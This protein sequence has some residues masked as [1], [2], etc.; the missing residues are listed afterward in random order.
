MRSKESFFYK[1]CISD[2]IIIRSE[3]FGG[4]IFNPKKEITIKVDIPAFNV[5]KSI[6]D[7]NFHKN[8]LNSTNELLDFLYRMIRL[9]IITQRKR[10]FII[11]PKLYEYKS[12]INSDII[13]FPESLHITLTYNCNQ[14]CKGCY[15]GLQKT[16]FDMHYSLYKQILDEAAREGILQLALGGGEPFYHPKIWEFLKYT[17]EKEILMNITTNGTLLNK[18]KILKLEKF[19]N[20]GRIQIS[21]DG[22]NQSINDQSRPN[23][24]KVLDTISNLS[25]SNIRFG[26]N[27]LLRNSNI[28]NL[29]DMFEFCRDHGANSLNLLRIKPP[30]IDRNWFEKEKLNMKSIEKLSDFLESY[31]NRKKPKI[32]F[33]A[34]F[35][36][37]IQKK[38][39]NLLFLN[40]YS[41]CSGGKNFLT[42]LPDGTII[43][44]THLR[45]K[46][47][48]VKAGIKNIWENSLEL[49]FL[50]NKKN[51]IKEPCK[52][53]EILMYCGGCRALALNE[54]G[55]FNGID[56]E[57]LIYKQIN[58]EV[59]YRNKKA[60]ISQ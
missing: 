35:S 40:D 25:S 36:Y 44:C 8:H 50:R 16:R 39:I 10:N 15:F 6:F 43:P 54:S 41:G 57:C 14:E 49:K 31:K 2:G 24:N 27:M 32:Y 42:I 5:L 30:I 1:Y 23:F 9:G 34:S 53:C 11:K 38:Q 21:L 26:I 22:T 47:G 20:L 33:D 46:I 3:F 58:N 28:N 4:L 60:N 12:H 51:W 59:I 29:M 37:L 13:N 7:K 52:S 56:R 18:D 55:S 48:K 19:K 45:W 17:D